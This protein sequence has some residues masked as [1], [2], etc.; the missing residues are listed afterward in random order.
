MCC[1]M[2]THR[3]GTFGTTITVKVGKDKEAKSFIVYKSLLCDT[4]PYFR[5]ALTGYFWES[6]TQIL[7]LPEDDPSVFEHFLLWLYNGDIFDENDDLESIPWGMLIDLYLFGEARGIPCLQNDT[8]DKFIDKGNHVGNVPTHCLHK[9]YNHT[10]VE[11][12]LRRLIV[13][14]CAYH[15]FLDHAEWF[16]HKSNYPQEFLIDLIKA[17]YGIHKSKS[18]PSTINFQESRSNYHV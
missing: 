5:V 15:G 14:R 6:E 8:I 2:L 4:A 17:Q 10:M 9:V 12:P 13:D 3:S 18:K 11:A 7:E 1:W 16:L